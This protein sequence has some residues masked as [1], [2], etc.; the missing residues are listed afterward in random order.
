MTKVLFVFGEI[1]LNKARVLNLVMQLSWKALILML[2]WM[3]IQTQP[4]IQAGLSWMTKP[5]QEVAKK[6]NII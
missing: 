6:L 1:F 3:G 5:R 4:T 2:I